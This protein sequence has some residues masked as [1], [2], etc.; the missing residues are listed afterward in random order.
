MEISRDCV[1]EASYSRGLEDLKLNGHVGNIIVFID[2]DEQD[3]LSIQNTTN[4]KRRHQFETEEFS[5]IKVR[6]VPGKYGAVNTSVSSVDRQNSVEDEDEDIVFESEEEYQ[7]KVE[8]I[9]DDFS[10]YE[11]KGRYQNHVQYTD[12]EDSEDSDDDD[13]DNSDEDFD[14]DD[15]DEDDDDNSIVFEL[16]EEY[17]N[18][19][20]NTKYQDDDDDDDSIVFELEEDYQDNVESTEDEDDENDDSIVFEFEEVQ[21]NKHKSSSKN[22]NHN[23]EKEYQEH[24]PTK[25][26]FNLQPT[27]HTMIKWNFAY[28]AARRGPWL[29]MACDRD[30]FKE[31]IQRLGRVLDQVLNTQHRDC[32]WHKR[33]ATEELKQ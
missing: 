10:V 19:V 27:V 5:N 13:D 20:Q 14:D 11:F 6:I 12:D 15:D 18:K 33:F 3:D 17:Q 22:H 21:N 23:N 28:R 16:E 9:Q 32:I 25:V 4:D 30:R 24:I 26:K 2:T 31:R 7:D 1:D 8:N 29:Q